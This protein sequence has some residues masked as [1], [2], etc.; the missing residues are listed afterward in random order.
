MLHNPSPDTRELIV[1]C[2]ARMIASRVH[3][4]RSGWKAVFVVLGIA[5][6]QSNPPL[7]NS[8]FDLLL[9][10]LDT[11]FGLITESADTLDEC[12]K[13]CVAFGCNPITEVALKAIHRLQSVADFLG[14]QVLSEQQQGNGGGSGGAD[15][16]STVGSRKSSTDI[17]NGLHLSP[18]VTEP[19]GTDGGASQPSSASTSPKP[20]PLT[21]HSSSL[22]G[23]GG[24]HA[25][26]GGTAT[27]SLT[28]STSSSSSSS[29]GLR[30]WFLLLTG[31]SR[32][33]GDARLTVR[34]CAL[35]SLFAV[36][37]A[38]GALF[39]AAHVAPHL[40]WSPLPHIR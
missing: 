7:V 18:A 22:A 28:S 23:V 34:S 27:P 33:V 36:L 39:S 17:T 6:K 25:L 31:L 35:E 15:S 16:S 4:I 13:C 10:I 38:H 40:L 14:Q 3:N 1:Q 21:P 32:L 37:N 8:A 2:L 20:L 5:A 9:Q 29:S 24:L 26:G 19:V 12:V 11:Y 30:V